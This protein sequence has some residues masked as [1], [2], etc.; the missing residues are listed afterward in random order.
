MNSSSNTLI[1]KIVQI[2]KTYKNW[3]LFFLD[4]GGFLGI[5][6]RKAVVFELRNGTLFK[7]RLGKRGDG[8][9]INEAWIVKPYFRYVGDAIKDNSVVIDIGAHIGAFSI[10]VAKKTRNVLIY[11]YEPCPENFDFLQTNIKLNNL[12]NNIKPFKLGI[13]GRAGKYRLF[14]DNNYMQLATM[15]PKKNWK[16]KKMIGIEC[17]TLKDIFVNNKINRCSF[18]K[19]D[20]EGAE[21]DILYN[22]PKEYLR[23]VE[24]ISIELHRKDENI[25][26]K[27]YLEGIGFEVVIDEVDGGYILYA[28]NYNKNTF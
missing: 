4:R 23:K 19:I 12:E 26:L 25:Q 11:S 18:L 6:R 1:Y 14:I 3:P 24:M 17:V 22:T 16:N 9:I 5:F 27:G 28:K 13:W 10:F 20:C 8:S 7:I 21:Y 15:Y 2:I